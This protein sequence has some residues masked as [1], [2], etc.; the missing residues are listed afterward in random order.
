MS[1]QAVINYEKQG[2]TG[3]NLAAG[4]PSPS[5]NRAR[6]VASTR[7]FLR[8]SVNHTAHKKARTPYGA[9]ALVLKLLLT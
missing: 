8:R 3:V 7:V 6:E 5:A 4:A 2:L 9:R 1:R